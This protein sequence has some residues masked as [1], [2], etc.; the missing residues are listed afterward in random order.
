MKS[1]K[2]R[3]NR[4]RRTTRKPHVIIAYDEDEGENKRCEI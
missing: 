2:G 4:K 3:K 1:G